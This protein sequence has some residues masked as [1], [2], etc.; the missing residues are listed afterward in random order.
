MISKQGGYIARGLAPAL[1]AAAPRRV[2]LTAGFQLASHDLGDLLGSLGITLFTRERTLVQYVVWSVNAGLL[3]FLAEHGSATVEEASAGTPL[4]V[5][6]ADALLGVLCALRLV[7]RSSGGRYSLTAASRD[8]L[9]RE[10]PFYLAD[11]LEPVGFPIHD[12]YLKRRAGLIARIRLRLLGYLPMLRFGTVPRIDNQHAR[13]LAACA[14]A[15]RTGEFAHAKRIADI[16]GGSGVFAIPLL[17]EYPNKRVVLTELPQ[18]LPNIRPILAAHG[19]EDRV[20][21]RAANVFAF[22]WD[23]PAC[24]GI[25][26]GNFLHAFDEQLGLKICREIFRLLPAGGT[27]WLHEMLWNDTRDGPLITALRHASMVSAG[28]GGGQRTGAEWM[29]LLQRAGFAETRVVPTASA[30]A[31]ITARKPHGP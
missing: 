10:S 16:A 12:V 31:L 7:S 9:I 30:F 26:I 11:Q 2:P 14:A 28:R 1:T 3:E 19:V 4:T 24:D 20:D 17:L 8:Y 15:V 13:N 29:S 18:A 6:G 5:R 23:L 25:F 21:L 27:V 22:P